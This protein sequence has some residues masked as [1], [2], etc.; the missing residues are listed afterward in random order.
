[1]ITK[2]QLFF[3]EIIFLFGGLIAMRNFD[4]SLI[5]RLLTKERQH[6]SPEVCRRVATAHRLNLDVV[7]FS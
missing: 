1:M 4:V 2:V 5:Q 6:V 7:T 3:I